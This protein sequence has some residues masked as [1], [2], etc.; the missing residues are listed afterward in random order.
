MLYGGR[1]IIFFMGL[2]SIYT[3]LLYNECFSRSFNLFGSAWNV[4]AMN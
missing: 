1:Y 4:S 2:F 3:G